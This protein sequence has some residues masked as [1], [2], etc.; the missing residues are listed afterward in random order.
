MSQPPS[1]SD[2]KNQFNGVKVFAATMAQDR[3][4]LGERVTAW[5]REHPRVKIVD[6]IV[7]QSSDNAFHCVAI[8]LFFVESE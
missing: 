6:R 1:D 2:K 3:E 4:Q 8:T 5:L 7:T